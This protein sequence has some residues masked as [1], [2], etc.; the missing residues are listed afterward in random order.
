MR[1]T[2]RYQRP[3]FWILDHWLKLF[4]W[5]GVSMSI[6]QDGP[7]SNAQ[8][9]SILEPT[10]WQLTSCWWFWASLACTKRQTYS[11][12]VAKRNDGREHLHYLSGESQT[13]WMKFHRNAD[14]SAGLTCLTTHLG[15]GDMTVVW[16]AVSPMPGDGCVLVVRL[17]RWSYREKCPASCSASQSAEKIGILWD[18]GVLQI[19]RQIIWLKRT[20]VPLCSGAVLSAISWPLQHRAVFSCHIRDARNIHVEMFAGFLFIYLSHFQNAWCGANRI[21]TWNKTNRSFMVLTRSSLKLVVP[22]NLLRRGLITAGTNGLYNCHV[23]N[24]VLKIE[25]LLPSPQLSSN[26]TRTTHHHTLWG[27]SDLAWPTCQYQKHLTLK[28]TNWYRKMITHL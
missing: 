8:H 15:L 17:Q 26:T 11:A 4:A 16:P 14:T 28:S 5:A 24:Q 25:L 1:G 13:K 22:P 23:V 27:R 3:D 7:R 10:K 12:R 20:A 19:L 18:C 9:L 6:A 21:E 2:Y